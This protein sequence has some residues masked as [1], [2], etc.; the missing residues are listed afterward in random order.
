MC[1]LSVER[2]TTSWYCSF[3]VEFLTSEVDVLCDTSHYVFFRNFY[4]VSSVYTVSQQTAFNAVVWQPK[5][6]EV[7][8]EYTLHNFSPF[9]VFLPKIIKIGGNLTKFWRKEFCTVFLKHGVVTYC[10]LTGTV[11]DR[12]MHCSIIS[13]CQ[14]AATYGYC[15]ALLFFNSDSC[16]QAY[17]KF[18]TCNLYLVLPHTNAAC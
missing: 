17:S 1:C 5:L 3:V 6:V 8:N 2:F 15:K 7:E 16:K 14:S 18:Q 4:G 13:S 10:P 11:D 9:A 12:I